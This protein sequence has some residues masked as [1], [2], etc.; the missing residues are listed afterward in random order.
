M[1]GKISE[2]ASNPCQF[3]YSQVEHWRLYKVLWRCGGVVRIHGCPARLSQ[4]D[5]RHYSPTSFSSTRCCQHQSK[6]T[7]GLCLDGPVSVRGTPAMNLVT[8]GRGAA[9]ALRRS[10][11]AR[12]RHFLDPTVIA[13]SSV[14]HWPEAASRYPLGR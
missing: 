4:V 1:S 3:V 5:V 12:R 14:H 2:F 9:W 8:A 13:L 6:R 7:T 11:R 10:F